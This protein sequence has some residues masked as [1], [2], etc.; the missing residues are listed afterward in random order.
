LRAAAIPVTTEAAEYGGKTKVTVT[1]VGIPLFVKL[2]SRIAWQ[3]QFGKIEA[4]F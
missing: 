4:L 3:Q 1:E 2:L